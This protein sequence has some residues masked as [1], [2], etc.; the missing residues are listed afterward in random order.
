MATILSPH[1][2]HTF[3][4]DRH[5]R[6][7]SGFTL[8]ELLTVVAILSI[9]V[10]ITFSTISI[11]SKTDTEKLHE[12]VY[13]MLDSASTFAINYNKHFRVVAD[14]G[15][16]N[17]YTEYLD[18][19]D[20]KWQRFKQIKPIKYADRGEEIIQ[21]YVTHYVLIYPSGQRMAE[22]FALNTDTEVVEFD[23]EQ[24]TAT[25]Q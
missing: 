6:C 16:G 19:T 14:D 2:N 23:A 11:Q 18:S 4:K 20:S 12:K 21:N 22:N 8:F 5:T 9:F 1:N 24:L 10:V 7:Q 17:I 3:S 13:S 25:T 15:A